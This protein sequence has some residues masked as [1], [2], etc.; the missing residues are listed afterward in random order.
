MYLSVCWRKNT[1]FKKT[2]GVVGVVGLVGLVGLVWLVVL[3]RQSAASACNMLHK[4]KRIGRSGRTGKQPIRP[5]YVF[6]A[7]IGHIKVLPLFKQLKQ[8]QLPASSTT[9]F[10][11]SYAPTGRA[12]CKKCKLLIKLGSIRLSREIPNNWTG[13]KGSATSHYH[14]AHGMQAVAAVRCTDRPTG[15]LPLLRKHAS[16]S[17]KDVQQVDKLFAKAM[18]DY[19]KKCN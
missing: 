5:R 6:R 10:L 9:E 18:K 15:S 19:Y 17:E 14:L 12:R 2:V 13:D 4:S 11:A 8:P 3:Y 7:K 1:P 16:L